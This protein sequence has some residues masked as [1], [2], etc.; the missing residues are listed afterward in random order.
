MLPEPPTDD[1]LKTPRLPVI[2]STLLSLT[3][4]KPMISPLQSCVRRYPLVLVCVGGA[5][6]CDRHH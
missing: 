2:K 1:V 3:G 6:D 4:A 5:S